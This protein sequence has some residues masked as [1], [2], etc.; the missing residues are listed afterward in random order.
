MC[1]FSRYMQAVPMKRITA[2]KCA[3]SF[4]TGWVS[5]FGSPVHIYCNRGAQ[6]TSHSWKNLAVF[7]GT[8]LHH[9]TAYHPQAQGIVERVN[10]TLKTS[11]KARGSPSEWHDNLPWALLSLRNSFN[12]DLDGLSSNKVV[13]KKPL[14]LRGEFFQHQATNALLSA[15][16]HHHLSS[17]LPKNLPPFVTTLHD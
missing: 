9:S 6:F 16:P 8:K 3:D 5:T 12:E 15:A 2:E 1:R 14:C 17:L 11:L 13:F 7:L 10:R 4:V